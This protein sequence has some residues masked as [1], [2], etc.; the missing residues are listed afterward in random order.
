[1][2]DVLIRL[3]VACFLFAT[4]YLCVLLVQIVREQ[5]H[6]QQQPKRRQYLSRPPQRPNQALENQLLMMVFGDRQLALRLVRSARK[7]Q[8]GR[9]EDWYWEKAIFDLERDRY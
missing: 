5:R 3:T 8:P 4:L 1:M 7:M 2:I 6:N 9:S